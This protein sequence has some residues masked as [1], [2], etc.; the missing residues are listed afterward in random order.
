MVWE[1]SHQLQILSL[2][3]LECWVGIKKNTFNDEKGFKGPVHSFQIYYTASFGKLLIICINYYKVTTI[4]AIQVSYLGLY[5]IN[6][7][8]GEQCVEKQSCKTLR[9]IKLGCT[10]FFI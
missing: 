4:E 1:F 7:P 3:E 6:L 8:A 9:N 2:S 5:E 10:H